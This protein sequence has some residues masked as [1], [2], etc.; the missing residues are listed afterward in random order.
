MLF[1]KRAEGPLF[2]VSPGRWRRRRTSWPLS[3]A[4]A[5]PR[6]PW[7]GR[8]APPRPAPHCCSP[9][10]RTRSRQQWPQH[11]RPSGAPGGAPGCSRPAY[12]GRSAPQS[13]GPSARTR[14]SPRPRRRGRGPPPQRPG[15]A[16]RA[17]RAP[18]PRKAPHARVALQNPAPCRRPSHPQRRSALL[19]RLLLPPALHHEVTAAIASDDRPDQSA[20]QCPAT[21]SHPVRRSRT[22]AQ[23]RPLLLRPRVHAAWVARPPTCP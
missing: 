3:A 17:T 9:R 21:G 10:R 22:P 11:Q 23:R 20:P 1:A 19:T 14:R 7:Q 15:T 4:A 2:E 5:A 12:P 8:S 6:C 18:H 16:V 13:A